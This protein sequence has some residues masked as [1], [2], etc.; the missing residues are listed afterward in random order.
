MG[1]FSR[2]IFS[3]ESGLRVVCVPHVFLMFSFARG[4]GCRWVPDT[5]SFFFVVGFPKGIFPFWK[6]EGFP[7]DNFF[8]QGNFQSTFPFWRGEGCRWDPDTNSE[9]SAACVTEGV[10]RRVVWLVD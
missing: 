8:F 3:I 10:A 4:E 7:L 5:N 9:K 2:G 1:V 6:G